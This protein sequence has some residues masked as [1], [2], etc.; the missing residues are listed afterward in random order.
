MTKELSQYQLTAK[1]LIELPETFNLDM[2]SFCEIEKFDKA[3]A[4]KPE[5]GTSFCGAGYLAAIDEYPED[6]WEHSLCAEHREFNYS[7]YSDSLIGDKELT[8]N[9]DEKWEFLFSCCWPNSFKSLKAR[10]QYALDTD[11]VPD[12]QEYWNFLENT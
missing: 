2:R 1:R 5:C 7:K 6:F 10:A 4:P 3:I 9:F 11:D 12:A 8:P